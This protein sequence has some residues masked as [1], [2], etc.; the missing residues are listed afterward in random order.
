LALG[1]ASSPSSNLST[2]GSRKKRIAVKGIN[3]R[4]PRSNPAMN[5]KEH[6]SLSARMLEEA[7]GYIAK[8]DTVQA[9]EKLYKTA[10][11]AVKAL[12]ASNN[13]PEYEEARA[14]GRW[15]ATLLHDA[16]ERLSET[17]DP[18]IRDEWTQAWFLHVEGFHE[19]RLTME[20]VKPRVRYVEELLAQ[21]KEKAKT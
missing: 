10:E 12:A 16:V 6:L 4:L 17:L 5:M 9:S 18:R 21:A 2:Q 19:A 7:R 15:T 14:D 8:G 3:R 13:L 1:E 20:L 11:E